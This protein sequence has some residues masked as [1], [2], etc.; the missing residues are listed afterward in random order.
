[1][2]AIIVCLGGKANA[3]N[4]AQ[5]LKALIREG[6]SQT[7]VKLQLRNRGPDAYKPHLFGESIIIE[8]RI[9]RDG[10]SGYKIKSA[11]GKTISTKREELAAMCDHMNIQVDNPMNVLSQDTAKQFLQA[12]TG[13]DKYKFFSRGTQLTQL[14]ID[15]ETIRECIDTMHRT[16]AVKKDGLHDLYEEAKAAQGR[17]KDMQAAATLELK[18]QDL[19]NQVAWAQIED[20][21]KGVKT[22][23]SK[24]AGLMTRIPGIEAKRAKEEDVIKEIDAQIQ[25]LDR[26]MVEHA[27]SGAPSLE[28]KRA[29]E[30][31]LRDKRNEFKQIQ[32]EEKT[33]NEEIK[34]LKEQI[35]DYE[36]KIEQTRKQQATAISRR[37]EAVEKIARL[38]EENERS[39]RQ[40]AEARE[41]SAQIEQKSDECR[42]RQDALSKVTQ[43][44][45]GDLQESRDRIRQIEAQ[46]QNALKAFGPMIPDVLRDIEEVTR[47]RGWRG[48]APVGPL[49]RHVKLR[50]EKWAQVLES[51][52]GGV[53]NAF[54]ITEDADR[55]TLNGILKKYRW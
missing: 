19:K 2:T 44:L 36:R 51:A 21:E 25:A 31:K 40:L 12:S 24:L 33:V 43:K 28:K 23:E 8:R 29:I 22:I 7:D 39:K 37:A 50:E 5:N 30:H 4:R 20:L 15:Y 14:S 1:M 9:S 49:G 55:T 41:S 27:N 3:T 26:D 52:L 46:K 11:K 35:K 6:A 17:F 10:T 16:L 53:L 42:D 47:R 13:E 45:R 34:S 38:E 18:V 48:D 32:D 54:A